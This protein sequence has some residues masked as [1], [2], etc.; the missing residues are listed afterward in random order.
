MIKYLSIGLCIFAMCALVTAIGCDNLPFGSNEETININITNDSKIGLPD[1]HIAI[2]AN[3][4]CG[5]ANE[6]SG[7]H[8][9]TIISP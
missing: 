2:P 3:E 5:T 4:S 8:G 7:C 9:K 1:E 6:K